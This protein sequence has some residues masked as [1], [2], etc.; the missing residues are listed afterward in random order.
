MCMIIHIYVIYS[1]GIY[2]KRKKIESN[3]FILTVSKN[4]PATLSPSKSAESFGMSARGRINYKKQ[5]ISK[6]AEVLEEVL[7]TP[8]I[9]QTGLTGEYDWALVYND[10]DKNVLINDVRE[11]LG[12]ELTQKKMPIEVLLVNK[13]SAP[14]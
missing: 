14:N 6:L 10:A 1:I 5:K 13:R 8:V 12:L 9:N 7:K 4:K 3:E 11:K 2:K